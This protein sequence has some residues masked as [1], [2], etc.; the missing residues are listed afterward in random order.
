M[1]YSLDQLQFS[2]RFATL[3]KS[4]I[5]FLL[6]FGSQINFFDFHLLA[7]LTR[8]LCFCQTKRTRNLIAGSEIYNMS[9]S[10]NRGRN[11]SG[12]FSPTN[13]VD[14]VFSLC[15][16]TAHHD[17]LSFEFRMKKIVGTSR[18]RDI[19]VTNTKK[20]LLSL[21]GLRPVQSKL[22]HLSFFFRLGACIVLL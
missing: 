8:K 11:H 10:W 12:I 21:A 16:L 14:W 2:T 18:Y 5:D 3:L 20:G 13:K 4:A 15:T 19:A 7:I 22:S 9:F 17:Y 1:K 6:P